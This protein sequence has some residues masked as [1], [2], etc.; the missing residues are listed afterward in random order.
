[1]LL[2][3]LKSRTTPLPAPSLHLLDEVLIVL[4]WCSRGRMWSFAHAISTVISCLLH[5]EPY[6]DRG[7]VL[8]TL[9]STIS[10]FNDLITRKQT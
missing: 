10:T 6:P 2:L 8:L 5:V 9:R 7:D 3:L 4:R 1:M